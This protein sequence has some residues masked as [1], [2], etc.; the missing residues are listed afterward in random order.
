MISR[1]SFVSSAALAACSSALPRFALEQPSGLRVNGGRLRSN[2]EALSAYG[3]P[4]GGTFA[5]GVSRTAYSRADIAGHQ[6]VMELMRAADLE[7]RFDPAANLLA[8]REGSDASLKPLLFG[9]HIDSVKNGGNFDG[10][11][12]ALGG[13]EVLQTLIGNGVRTRHPLE[14]VIWSAEESNY[15]DGL[16]G[17]RAAAGR[18][19]PDEMQRV[20]DGVVKRDAIRNLGGDPDRM[21]EARRP[22]GSF[23]AYLELHIEQGGTL[24]AA[25]VPIG[26][27]E[28]IVAIDDYEVSVRGFANHAGTTPMAERKDALLAASEMVIAVHE[29]ATSIPG[30]QVATVG[31]MS[32]VPGAPNVVPG[33]VRFTVDMRDLDPAKLA[34]MGQRLRGR[35]R[36]IASRHQCQVEVQRTGGDPAALTAEPVRRAIEESAT[37][38]GLRHMRL[39]SG[40]GHDAQMMALLGPIGMIFIP[41]VGGISHSPHELSR[42]E[43]VTN[44]ADV[45]LGT[46]LRLD[47]QTAG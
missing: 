42:W 4:P 20:Q 16:S 12:G 11:V 36:E 1:R 35:L 43:D 24:D 46:I 31:E 8:T 10:D 32:V 38:L 6:F 45:L 26:V 23:A 2:L 21:A 47:S 29:I 15:G 3:R 14:L 7:P 25:G 22:S 18:L 33:E 44:G 34:Q 39:P 41:S 27:V 17:S 30:R 19:E 13:L 40:A 5:S 37:E 28:G 9:S